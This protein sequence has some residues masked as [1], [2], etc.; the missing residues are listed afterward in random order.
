M[1]QPIRFVQLLEQRLKATLADKFLHA[2]LTPVV[3]REIRDEIR[4]QIDDVFNKSTTNLSIEARQW[5]AN[6]FFENIKVNDE[7]TM[8][9]LV[10]IKEHPLA[11]MP[12]S[13]I[14][15]LKNLFNDTVVGAEL[16]DEYNRRS[17]S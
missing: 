14:E 4:V 17:A 10:V 9:D 1:N 6:K 11:D 15:L 7:Q 2:Q 16:L 3:L 5:V 12:F 8:H 13:D